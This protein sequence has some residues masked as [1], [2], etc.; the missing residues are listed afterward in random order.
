[1]TSRGGGATL[2][3]AARARLAG[4]ADVLISG[5]PGWPSASGAQ[6]HGEWMDRTFAA[7]PENFERAFF[8]SLKSAKINFL[9][10][11]GQNCF[12][13]FLLKTKC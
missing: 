6:V 4:F 13:S 11:K 2:D 10:L 8:I 1:M 3:D 5:S 9:P 7:R 12:F